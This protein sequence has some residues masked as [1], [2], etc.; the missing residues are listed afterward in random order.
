MDDVYIERNRG[1]FGRQPLY[2]IHLF[3]NDGVLIGHLFY[4]MINVEIK[5][6]MIG[7]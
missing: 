7:I 3:G 6:K 4:V 1:Q 2:I 5:K